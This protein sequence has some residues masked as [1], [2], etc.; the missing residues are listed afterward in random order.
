MKSK[1]FKLARD[2]QG[3][4]LRPYGDSEVFNEKWRYIVP[5]GGRGSRKSVSA[6][7][8]GIRQSL[9][10]E[11][12]TF[13]CAREKKTSTDRSVQDMIVDILKDMEIKHT[14]KKDEINLPNNSNIYFVGL[15]NQYKT[16]E[17]MKSFH[18][19][20]LLWYEEAH[21]LSRESMEI[22]TPT[23][24]APGSQIM[25]T[26][27]PQHETDA[28][29]QDFVLRERKNA[30]VRL[31]N[32]D[33]N[34]FFPDELEEERLFDKEFKPY[35]Y[36]HKWLGDIMREVEGAMWTNQDVIDMRAD[37]PPS[38]P[39]DSIVIAIDPAG[40]K[41]KRSDKTGIVVVARHDD[42]GYILHSERDLGVT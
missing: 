14:D 9:T 41:K 32:Y 35:I 11:D 1:A 2:E 5:Y 16:D 4:I 30:C 37:A 18:N 26:F 31:M 39:P 40:T 7:V 36:N 28:V 22:L 27:N 29:W 23:V 13:V 42:T 6:A 20:D 10:Y 17:G 12:F 8:Y 21:K 25:L 19:I 15:S 24:R 3:R 33:S 34:K 38:G